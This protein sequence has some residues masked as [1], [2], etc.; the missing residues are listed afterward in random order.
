MLIYIVDQQEKHV[1]R[2][3]DMERTVMRQQS[4]LVSCFVP[5]N[6]LLGLFVVDMEFILTEDKLDQVM[7]MASVSRIM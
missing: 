7:R 3:E 4:V 1:Q 2:L 6:L 5:G